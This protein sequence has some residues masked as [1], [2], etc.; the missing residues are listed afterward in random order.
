MWKS[1]DAD[2]GVVCADARSA[3]Q[4]LPDDSVD[5]AFWSPPYNVGKSY[6]RG[7][8]HDE[9]REMLREVV[10]AHARPVKPGGFVVVNI[11]DILCFPDPALPRLQ[12]DMVNGKRSPVTKEQVVAAMKNDP[13]A[14]RTEIAASLGCSEQTVQR[15]LEGNN[16]RG[17]KAAPNTR[18]RLVGGMIVEMAADAGFHL[19]DQRV[20][21]KDPCWANSRWHSA[22]YRAV[23]E[24]E[25]IYVFCAP[26]VVQFDRVRLTTS[27]WAAWGSR[28]VWKIRSVTRNNRHEAEF[29]EEL[30][31]RVVKLYSPP[32][33]LVVD[34]FAGTGTTAV[35]AKRL[36]RRWRISDSDPR[37]VH[38]ASKRLAES[39]EQ[40]AV[41]L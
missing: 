10:R 38:L 39:V 15:R 35:A 30:A 27:E 22:S 9:W 31:L 28:G 20:W 37:C 1:G 23:D 33:G 4:Q 2:R 6:E 29:P 36:G 17:R 7:Q 14:S 5:L 12:A 34:P 8:S 11:A 40:T 18:I 16:A 13:D 19:Y 26:G 21:H 41:V 3:L 32:D 24:F 25:H